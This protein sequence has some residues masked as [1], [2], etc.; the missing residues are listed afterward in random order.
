MAGAA[1]LHLL[2]VCV[3]QATSPTTANGSVLLFNVLPSV[4]C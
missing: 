1:S 4:L 3:A 2:S